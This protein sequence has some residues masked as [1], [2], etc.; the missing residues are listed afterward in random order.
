M[1]LGAAVLSFVVFAAGCGG[2][3]GSSSGGSGT[4]SPAP[5][6]APYAEAAA[7]LAVA[8]LDPSPLQA[9]EGRLA[10]VQECSDTPTTRAWI[11]GANGTTE[12]V[13]DP[14]A[15][16]GLATGALVRASGTPVE[17]RLAL[18]SIEA[19]PGTEEPT[20]ALTRTTGE[21]T[22]GL[23]LV[24]FSDLALDPGTTVAAARTVLGQ[25]S[26]FYRACSQGKTWLSGDAF[27]PVTISLSSSTSDLDAIA[28]VASA[29]A[30]HSGF[31]VAS[32]AHVV[33]VLPARSGLSWWG[34]GTI[35]GAP[36]IAWING[37]LDS[38]VLSHELGHGFGLYHSHSS[39]QE[40]GDE[41]DVMGFSKGEFN[42]FQRERLGWSDAGQVVLATGNGT[43]HLD[44][45]EAPT[46]EAHVLKV[47]RP[48]QASGSFFYVEARRAAAPDTA[49]V[50]STNVFAGVLVHSARE[51]DGNSSMLLD[52]TPATGTLD[53]AA[54]VPGSSFHDAGAG[55]TLEVLAV[56]DSG[57][58]VRVTFDGGAAP[59]AAAAASGVHRVDSA[60][61][62]GASFSG[63]LDLGAGGTVTTASWSRSRAGARSRRAG[64]S[65]SRESPRGP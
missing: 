1:K 50:G 21:H 44:P 45:Y 19:I 33:F 37:R 38:Q 32:Y 55:V 63:A 15:F 35:G 12:L 54:L 60:R 25:T 58:E 41:Y 23:V 10:L 4:S 40:Y 18:S 48:D 65:R 24:N 43:L 13:A 36:S 8:V 46:G 34:L 51:G 61:I 49:L 28:T 29:A 53:D 30:R 3:G 2:G 22:V 62:G 7:A 64:R 6:A 20:P 9:V 11:R 16:R 42:A 5:D 56:D 57:A 59:A 26:D 31:N 14:G 17:G 47:A 52:M 39:G 27:G